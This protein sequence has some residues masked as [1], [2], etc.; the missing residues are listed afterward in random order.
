MHGI[1]T[2]ARTPPGPPILRPLFRHD[3]LGA[4]PQGSAETCGQEAETRGRGRE[5]SQ[6][7]AEANS[8]KSGKQRSGCPK[9]HI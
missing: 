5:A 3:I 4:R 1:V 7:R 6:G 2:L 9:T 8:S